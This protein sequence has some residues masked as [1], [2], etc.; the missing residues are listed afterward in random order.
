M[1]SIC[2]A[3]YLFIVIE[4]TFQ[5]APSIA[6]DQIADYCSEWSA[7]VGDDNAIARGD[8]DNNNNNNTISRGDDDGFYNIRHEIIPQ[9]TGKKYY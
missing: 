1:C 6:P 7:D 3:V 9:R 8:D 4:Q 5:H 2:E